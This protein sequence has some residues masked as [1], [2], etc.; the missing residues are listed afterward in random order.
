MENT[1]SILI[2]FILIGLF[3]YIYRINKTFLIA[4]IL[5]ILLLIFL[6]PDIII[7]NILWQ[8]FLK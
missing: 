5:I 3:I 1:F 6:M 4:Y 7:P 2:D 8:I